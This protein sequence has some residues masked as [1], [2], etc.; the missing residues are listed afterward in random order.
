[1]I[2]PNNCAGF[3]KKSVVGKSQKS[4]CD[5][6]FFSGVYQNLAVSFKDAS[7]GCGGAKLNERK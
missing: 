5:R 6:F 4:R 7:S 1:M 2:K 3:A